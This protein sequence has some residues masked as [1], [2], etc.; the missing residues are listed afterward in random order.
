MSCLA[1]DEESLVGAVGVGAVT[2]GMCR[3]LAARQCGARRTS[4]HLHLE[5]LDEIYR[6]VPTF[7]CEFDCNDLGA[8]WRQVRHLGAFDPAPA[9]VCC[10]I[11]STRCVDGLLG[12]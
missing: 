2:K 11:H 3:S 8:H 4:T 6:M 10:C 5:Q 1:H 7:L 9:A 12:A